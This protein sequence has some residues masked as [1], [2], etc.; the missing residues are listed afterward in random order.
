MSDQDL[1]R[2]QSDL[3]RM[4]QRRALESAVWDM[5]MGSEGGGFADADPWAMWSGGEI[6]AELRS[7]LADYDRMFAEV[8]ERAGAQAVFDKASGAS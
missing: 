8:R 4:R 7:V 6:G 3:R 1:G 5:L 2:L